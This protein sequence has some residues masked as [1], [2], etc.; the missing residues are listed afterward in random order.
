MEAQVSGDDRQPTDLGW[1]LLQQMAAHTPPLSQSD[2]ARRTGVGQATISR[3]IYHPIRPDTDKLAKLAHALGADLGDLLHLAGHGRPT[4]GP[5]TPPTADPLL[6][7]ISILIG[8]HSPVPPERLARL[9]AHLEMV[10]EPY[11]Q[12]LPGLRRIV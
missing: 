4:H 1:W 8:D 9:R 12:H 2:L 3:W 7:K 5:D 6:A 11:E 10:I